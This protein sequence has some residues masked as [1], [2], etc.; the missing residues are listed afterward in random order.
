M[1]QRRPSCEASPLIED[2]EL[3]KISS[4]SESRRTIAK[5]PE[6]IIPL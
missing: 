2:V 4:A 5:K 6:Q 1:N 3:K